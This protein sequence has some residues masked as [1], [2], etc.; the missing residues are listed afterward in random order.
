MRMRPW[1]EEGAPAT[2]VSEKVWSYHLV[3]KIRLVNRCA[4]ARDDESLSHPIGRLPISDT[5]R[6]KRALGHAGRSTDV[7]RGAVHDVSK[8]KTLKVRSDE[9][10]LEA[11][12]FEKLPDRRAREIVQ[13]YVEEKHPRAP[14]GA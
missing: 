10:D 6:T 5:G 13:V 8:R 7:R 2:C 11:R 14:H 12:I 3:E 4:L 1:I 9:N